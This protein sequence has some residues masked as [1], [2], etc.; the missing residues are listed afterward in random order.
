MNN[1]VIDLEQY[2]LDQAEKDLRSKLV[3]FS[4]RQEIQ[5][6]IGEAFYIWRNDPEIADDK[7]TDQDISDVTFTKFFDW[8]LYDFKLID[9]GKSVI[10]L[11]Y[12]NDS[13]KLS[14]AE[15]SIL[16]HWLDNL[17]SYFEIEHIDIGEG[18]RIKDI[19]TNEECSVNDSSSSKQLKITDIVGARPLKTGKNNYFSGVISVYPYSSKPLFLDF[20]KREFNEYKKTLG[21]NASE[22][23]FLKNWGFLIGNYIDK[24][25]ENPR[26]LTPGGDK[27]V[28]ASA[29]YKIT[30]TKKVLA[31]LKSIKALQ[32]V[33]SG[34]KELTVFIWTQTNGDNILAT[35]EIE[36]TSLRINSHSLNSLNKAK[37]YIEN[38]LKGLINHKRDFTKQLGSFIKDNS[39]GKIKPKKLPVGVRSKKEMDSVL[40]EYYND[41]IDE[42]NKA[43]N[44]KSPR[45]ALKTKQG[46]KKLLAIL[47]ELENLYRHAK[48]RGEPYFDI[49]RLRDKLKL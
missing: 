9:V 24:I 35:I 28:L 45:D 36:E 15:R 18:C 41:W 48:Q 6:Q 12:E 31:K 7:Y 10:E 32:E 33:G 44:D 1:S 26:F 13:K 38:K 49:E 29:N 21:R 22:K 20:F 16:S 37:N 47:A 19:F 27:F 3:D 40:S 14:I 17:Y 46:R 4:H 34:T 23:E 39:Q 25:L 2:K 11:F 42:P 8:F 43:L 5:T 30:D